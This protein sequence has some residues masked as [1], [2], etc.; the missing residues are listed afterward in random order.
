MI[1]GRVTGAATRLGRRTVLI[2]FTGTALLFHVPGLVVRLFNSDEASLATMASVLERGGRLYHQTADRKPPI[3]PYLYA[4]VFHLTGT[5]D[6]R[7]VRL[8]ATLSLVATAVLL[9]DEARRRY[10]SDVLALVAGLLFLVAYVAFFPDDSQAATFE[11]FQLL[12][13]TGAV[14]AAGRDRPLAAGVLLALA[15]LCKQTALTAVVP[16]AYIIYRRSPRGLPRV[17]VGFALPIVLAAVVLGPG[18]FLLWTVTGNGGYLGGVGSLGAAVVRALGMTAALGALELGLVVA[19]AHAARRRSASVDL[20]LWLASGLIAVVAGFRFFG[21]YYLPLLPPAV[22]IAV[23]ALVDLRRR[24][25][26]LLGASV[27]A[28]AVVCTIIGF[29]PTGDNANIPVEPLAE[30][31]RRVTGPNETIFVWGD[32]PELYWASGRQPASRFVHTGFLTGNSGGRLAGSG[33][34]EN[35]LPGA[36]TML[37]DDLRRRPADLIVDTSTGAIRHQNYYPMRQTPLWVLVRSRYRLVATVNGVRLYHLES[38][39]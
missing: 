18:P 35:A 12:P 26:V 38:S 24:T 23:S 21:H 36:W 25:H 27:L 30:S 33:T 15:T 6:L 22:L 9:A 39:G 32:L 11:V 34:S 14:V 37:E 3:V 5:T 13:M 8:L 2:W 4:I 31:V 20:W 10:D 1:E 7:P 17:A 29:F 16:V 28:P 19:C